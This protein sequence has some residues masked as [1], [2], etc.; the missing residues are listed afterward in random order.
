MF[1]YSEPDN[2]P[3]SYQVIDGFEYA[4]GWPE[5]L[6]TNPQFTIPLITDSFETI[7]GWI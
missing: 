4:D 3:Q 1:F 7:E 5:T 6:N 2:Q